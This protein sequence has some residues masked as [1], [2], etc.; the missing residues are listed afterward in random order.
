MDDRIDGLSRRA[1]F[2]AGGLGALAAAGYAGGAEAEEMPPVA[3][4]GVEKPNLKLVT[5]FLKSWAAKD[6]DADKVVPQYIADDCLV[7]MEENKPPLTNAG[8]IASE[9]KAFTSNGTRIKVGIHQTFAKGPIV[10]TYR[11]DTIVVPGKPDQPFAVAGV[12]IV[13]NGK[14]KEWS[15][16]LV[17]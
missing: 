11:T 16:Y 2:L 17:A 12:F 1:L 6:F 3:P 9:L 8:A 10:V 5:D 15:D 13:K 7:R 14:I 4:A